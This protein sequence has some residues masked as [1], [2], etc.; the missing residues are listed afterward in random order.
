LIRYYEFEIKQI[1]PTL[2]NLSEGEK[3]RTF[4]NIVDITSL[5]KNH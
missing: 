3:E 2:Y 1:Q 4:L 5:I